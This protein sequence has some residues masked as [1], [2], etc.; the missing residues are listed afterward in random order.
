M[1]EIISKRLGAKQIGFMQEKTGSRQEDLVLDNVRSVDMIQY[2][3]EAEFT[4]R[5]PVIVHCTHLS[6]ED[7][8]NIMKYSEGSI[9]KQ[10]KRDFLSYGIDIYSLM[11]A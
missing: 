11:T 1:A 2:G 8:F 5:L 3:F 6:A 9:L 10:Y 4:G 7:L